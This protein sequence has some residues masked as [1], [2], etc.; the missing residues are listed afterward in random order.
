MKPEDIL[1]AL[2]QLDDKIIL[3]AREK[4][5]SKKAYIYSAAAIAAT[6]LILAGTVFNPAFQLADS[7]EI[8]VDMAPEAEGAPED[9]PTTD[10]PAA[11]KGNTSNGTDDKYHSSLSGSISEYPIP[12][13]STEEKAFAV[14]YISEGAT[15]KEECILVSSPVPLF[16]K[17]KEL[18]GIGDEVELIDFSA[19]TKPVTETYYAGNEC[20]V[21]ITSDAIMCLNVTVSQALSDYY[22]IF[23]ED[24]LI[25]S[26][27][28]TMEGYT[29]K[30]F[31]EF[32]VILK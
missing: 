18:H 8:A 1:D 5:K 23:G 25:S 7:S 2:G 13:A 14:F 29:G 31:D 17:W 3:D 21:G 9:S 16:E 4:P 26:L 24:E 10:D 12:E 20:I 32:N 11:N 6:F 19:S 28:K 15:E 30:H 27:V 22:D